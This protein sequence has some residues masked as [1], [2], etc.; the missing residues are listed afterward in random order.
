MKMDHTEIEALSTRGDG[1]FAF[2]RWG[3][4]L[5][6]VVFGVEDATLGV[7]KGAVEAV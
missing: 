3:R 6:P 1:G 4:P 5:A 7:I 2:A